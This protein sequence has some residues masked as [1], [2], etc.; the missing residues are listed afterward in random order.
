ML[1]GEDPPIPQAEVEAHLD[2]CP[3]CAAWYEQAR[4]L[5]RRVPLEP[6]GP[7]LT[8]HL[9]GVVEAHICAC[10]EGGPCECTNC[11]CETCTCKTNA[12]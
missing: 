7:D 5:Q 3:D 6:S 11:R 1:D 4:S 12:G 9:I 10:H 2:A 8:D